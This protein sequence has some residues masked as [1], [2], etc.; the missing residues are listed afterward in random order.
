MQQPGDDARHVEL[1]LGDDAGDLERMGEVGLAGQPPL[2]AVHLGRELVG[3]AD[4]AGIGGRIVGLDAV[5]EILEG[6]GD[7]LSLAP[8]S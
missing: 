5:D 4:R 8:E 6:H 7:Q 2:A 3:P 1:Q